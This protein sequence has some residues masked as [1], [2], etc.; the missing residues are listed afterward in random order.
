MG[1]ADDL[2]MPMRYRFLFLSMMMFYGISYAQNVIDIHCHN[3]LSEFRA[4]LDRH[5]ASLEETFPLPEWSVEA[6]LKF[7]DEAGI[8]QSVLSMPA[9]QP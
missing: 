3:V 2:T 6:H 7:M 1:N 4:L 8:G 9:P 5:D